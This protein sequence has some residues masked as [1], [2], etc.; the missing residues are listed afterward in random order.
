MGANEF[1]KIVKDGI[2]Q[3]TPQKGD[4]RIR[5]LPPTWPDPKHYGF[6]I[7]VHYGVG[8]DR[9]SY[10]DLDKMKEEPDPITE[11]V[12]ELRRDPGDMTDDEIKAMDSKRRVGI[13]LVDRDD[14]AEGV[15]FWA[16]PWTVDKEISIVSQDKSSGEVLMIDHPEDGYDVTFRKDGE[17]RNTKYTGVSI[18]R[19]SSP[20]G[21]AEWL[22][23][24]VDSPIPSILQYFTYDEIAKAFGGGGAHRERDRDA[25]DGRSDRGNARSRDDRGREDDRGA[26]GGSS[27]DRD[28]DDRDNRRG[29]DDGKTSDRDGREAESRGSRDRGGRGDRD[30]SVE[31]PALTWETVHEMTSDELDALVEAQDLDLDPSKATDDV[32]LAAWICEDLNLEKAATTSRRRI[33]EPK[34]DAEAGDKLADMR[35]R[36][37]RR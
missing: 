1:D 25:E 35:S 34:P 11:E 16:M 32:E 19:R 36:R 7:Y 27:R 12:V 20:L 26:R 22:D 9:G 3:W 15:Q 2:K 29:R 6:D 24:A 21:K 17:K 5:I 33:T 23:F 10:L 8:A 28:P 14:E 31:Q 30:R 4:N 18:S 13:Y 37:E